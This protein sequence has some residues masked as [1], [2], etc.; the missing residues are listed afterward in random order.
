[1]VDDDETL[2]MQAMEDHASGIQSEDFPELSERATLVAAASAGQSV[3]PGE[4]SF[5]QNVAR[6]AQKQDQYRTETAQRRAKNTR[7]N[8]LSEVE[9]RL[10][11]ARANRAANELRNTENEQRILLE[12][13][14]RRHQQVLRKGAEDKKWE[15]AQI[16]SEQLRIEAQVR[17]A[18]EL[19]TDC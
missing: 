7:G 6:H 2:E 4:D 3:T 15:E 8:L 17:I 13:A 14:A 11:R 5:A 12:A 9:Q 16:K 19:I 10:A 18:T 1:M